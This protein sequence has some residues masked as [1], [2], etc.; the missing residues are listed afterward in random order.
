MIGYISLVS[1][2]LLTG[3]VVNFCVVKEIGWPSW[4]EYYIFIICLLIWP[5]TAWHYLI[6]K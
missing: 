1:L 4:R 3:L 5:I 6:K 2:W